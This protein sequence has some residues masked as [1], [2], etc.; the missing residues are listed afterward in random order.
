MENEDQREKLEC[1]QSSRPEALETPRSR[2][3]QEKRERKRCQVRSDCRRGNE[4]E[5]GC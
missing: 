5:Q 1:D 3:G 4:E 2:K